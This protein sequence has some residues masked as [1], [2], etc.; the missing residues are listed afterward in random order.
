M[1]RPSAQ[2]LGFLAV[3]MGAA[4]ALA[5][6]AP[7]PA[8]APAVQADR[9]AADAAAMYPNDPAARHVREIYARGDYAEAIR[10]G[11][12][13]G[14]AGALTE[15][16]R[17]ALA[18][19][20]L[21]KERCLDCLKQAEALARRAI[22]ADPDRPEPYVFLA[23]AI[24]YQARILGVTRAA[25]ARDPEKAKHALDQALK[26][27]P[28]YPPALAALGGWNIE[29]VRLGG[30]ILGKAMYGADAP[31]GIAM[32]RRALKAAPGNL[33]LWYQFALSLSG[34]ALDANRKQI[35]DSLRHAAGIAPRSAYERAVVLRC[36]RL[37][38]L[39]AAG[40]DHTYSGIVDKY[41][42]YW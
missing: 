7:P 37:L 18:D 34:Y 5:G 3:L 33:V 27:A 36:E 2:I 19:A 28:G 31:A 16:A 17:A 9:I 22:M 41:Q 39:L 11:T 40:D 38:R 10:A 24:G 21:R 23:A 25:F 20:N 1:R 42:G 35:A 29:I 13:A 4:P 6:A 30:R 15:A 14:T 32:F 8:S 12:M 26:V